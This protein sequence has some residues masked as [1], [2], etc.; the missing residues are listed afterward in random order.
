MRVTESQYVAACDVAAQVHQQKIVAA[1]GI[2]ILSGQHGINKN[3]A[4]DF[5]DAYIREEFFALRLKHP[6]ER[7]F[8][9][10]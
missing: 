6:P 10:R 3:S 8:K 5:I 1:E 9:P 2:R 7:L 4:R